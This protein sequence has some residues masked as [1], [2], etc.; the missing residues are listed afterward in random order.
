MPLW[1]AKESLISHMVERGAQKLS[2]SGVTLS[3]CHFVFINFEFV[4]AAQVSVPSL[5]LEKTL[6]DMK[7]N[8]V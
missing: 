8:Q 1:R 6:L 3:L 2:E 7:I 5:Y 4:L